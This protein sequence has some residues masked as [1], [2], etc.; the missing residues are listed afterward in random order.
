MPADVT[1]VNFTEDGLE[2]I[3]DRRNGSSGRGIEAIFGGGPKTRWTSWTEL[4]SWRRF[5]GIVS[6]DHHC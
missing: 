3:D 6:V 5:P 1:K 4:P 2:D